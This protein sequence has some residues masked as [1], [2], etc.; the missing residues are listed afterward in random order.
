[1]RASM[2]LIQTKAYRLICC[3]LIVEPCE[4]VITVH[5]IWCVIIIY[6]NGTKL[7]FYRDLR[8]NMTQWAVFAEVAAGTHLVALVLH[9]FKY[10]YALSAIRPTCRYTVFYGRYN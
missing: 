10:T 9:F 7:T 1:M 5:L 6:I 8:A 4:V 3:R 2:R